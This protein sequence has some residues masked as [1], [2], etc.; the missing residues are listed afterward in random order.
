MRAKDEEALGSRQ[1]ALLKAQAL[2]AKKARAI[3][4]ASGGRTPT[5]IGRL[6]GHSDTA[7]V[8]WLREAGVPYRTKSGDGLLA[9]VA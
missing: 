1:T 2:A 4:L 9:T 8:K 7:I 5:E 3:H 6:L